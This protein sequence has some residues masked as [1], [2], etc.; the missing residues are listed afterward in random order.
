MM[1][2]KPALKTDYLLFLL[3]EE[4]IIMEDC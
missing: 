4:K 3:C 2:V 1:V